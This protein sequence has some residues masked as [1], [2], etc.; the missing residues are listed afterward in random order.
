MKLPERGLDASYKAAHLLAKRKK[1]HTDAESVIAPSL[2]IIVEIML[3]S[4][5]ADTVNKV[6]L[7]NDPIS[8]RIEDLFS[9]INDQIREH[10][11][12]QGQ[13]DELPQLWTLQVDE[14][15]DSTGKAHLLAFIRFVKNG[16]LV[17]QCLF[18][19]E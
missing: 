12:V 17:S 6:P 5:A 13:D 2:S 14:S 16:S 15:T 11:D 18:C 3:G 1:A 10:F 19:K 7:S 4:D 9:D 8:R